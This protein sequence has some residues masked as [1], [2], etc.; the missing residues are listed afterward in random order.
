MAVAATDDKVRLFTTL[1]KSLVSEAQANGVPCSVF[2]VDYG[3]PSRK[4]ATYRAWLPTLRAAAKSVRFVITVLPFLSIDELKKY[5]D[6]N[7]P[8]AAPLPKDPDANPGADDATRLRWMLARRL[9]RAQRFAEAVPYFQPNERAILQ[10]YV[11]ALKMAEN[12][13]LP[14]LERAHACFTA[15][16][17]ARKSGLEIMGTEVEPDGFESEGMYPPGHLDTE[18]AEG[19]Y[20]RTEFD[21]QGQEFTR[22]ESVKFALP[23]SPAE[24]RRLAANSPQPTR[25]YHYRWVASELAWRAAAWMN[26]NT[27]ELADVLNTGGSWIKDRDDRGADKFIQAMERRCPHTAIG[28][29]ESVKHWFVDQSGPWSSALEKAD[30]AQAAESEKPQ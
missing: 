18:R 11:T 17:I 1:A 14:K 23:V 12:P 24:K 13:K 25:R 26:D 22:K 10:R 8:K 20:V 4:L 27:E 15:A 2:Q 28:Q 29:A 16:W 5:V 6:A 9:V 3:C 30:T 21:R 7:Y 19:K